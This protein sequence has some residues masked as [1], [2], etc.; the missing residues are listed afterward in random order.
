VTALG[1][2]T[3]KSNVPEAALRWTSARA[4]VEFG[5]STGTLRKLLN[6]T[7]AKPGEDNSYSSQE[8][9][10]A[11]HGQLH[12]EKNQNQGRDHQKELR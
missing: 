2:R 10:G 4:A 9:V 11:I 12:L 5:L 1:S 8:V 6:R 3:P 7:A